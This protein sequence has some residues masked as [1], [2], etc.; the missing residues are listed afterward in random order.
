M[1]YEIRGEQF[2][3]LANNRAVWAFKIGGTV[4]PRPAPMPPATTREWAGR[5][6]DAAPIQLGTV[7][8]FNIASANKKIDWADDYGLSPSR[9]RAKAGT[10]VTFTNSSTISHTIAA[11]DGSWKTNPIKPG[12][13]VIL[14]GIR[15]GVYEYVCTDHPWTIGQL[16][17][18]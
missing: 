13:S 18:E 9:V 16:I 17:V 5:I 2:V 3:A 7:R 8:T 1:T 12:E 6:E 11:R 10:P 14:A 4:P 15:A